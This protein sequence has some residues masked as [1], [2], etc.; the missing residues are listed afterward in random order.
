MKYLFNK[1]KI[2]FWGMTVLMTVSCKKVVDQINE[3]GITADNFY[4]TA[5]DADNGI[6]ACYD[7]FQSPF[8]YMIWGDGRADMFSVTDRSDNIT[9]QIINGNVDANNFYSS[10]GN[11]YNVI[12]RTNSVLK[13]VP[14]IQDASLTA[15]KE[16]ILGEGYFLRGLAYFYLVR[17]FDNVP[18]ILEPYESLSQDFFPK[19]SPKE[20]TFAQI[21]LDFK[22][23]EQRLTDKP[24]ATTLENKGR[25]TLGAVRAALTDLYLWQKKYKEAADAALKVINSTAAYSLVTGAN[26]ATNFIAKNTTESIFEIQFNN[27]YLEPNNNNL[28]TQ[29]LP[30]GGSN[31]AGGQWNFKPSAK[32]VSTFTAGDL[33]IGATFKNT[34]TSPA[35]WRD[36]NVSYINKYQ[37]TLGAGNAIRFQ[38]ANFII[39]R[40]ADVLLMRAEAL[41]ELGQTPAAILL[42]NQVRNRAGLLNTTSVSQADIRLAIENERFLELAFEGKRYF[43]LKR[44]GRYVAVTGNTNPDWLIWPIVGVELVKNRNLIQNKG[45]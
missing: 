15:R 31:Y 11:M 4:K 8:N 16:R 14:P 24:Y 28:V 42:L 25:A 10:W 34:G 17:T 33:R 3:S 38:D 5:S 12:K 20:A 18:L 29:F 27:T 21:E 9:Q 7:A 36:V 41:N 6:N 39:Y 44:T 22:A 26:Y 2:I 1:I 40:L 43:D 45:Y 35:P 13:N 23:A 37:G 32:L 19:Q 30:L